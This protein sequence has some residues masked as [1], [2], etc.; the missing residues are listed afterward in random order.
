MP[1]TDYYIVF[2]FLKVLSMTHPQYCNV[3][4]AEQ[5]EFI[6]GQSLLHVRVRL[7]ILDF[8]VRIVYLLSY[9]QEMPNK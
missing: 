1:P 3:C 9:R 6:S 2:S 7:H 4:P 8:V 5:L